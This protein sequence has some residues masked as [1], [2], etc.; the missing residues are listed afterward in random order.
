MDNNP[1]PTEKIIQYLDGDLTGEELEQFE[2]SLSND[3]QV[4]EELEN[5]TLAKKA[6]QSY[7]LKNQ[8][9]SVHRDM[10]NELNKGGERTL[11]SR[12][13]P[14]VRASLKIAA[15]LLIIS[16]SIGLYQYVTITPSKL[17]QDNYSP[18][19]VSVSRGEVAV[20]NLEKAYLNKD[21]NQAISIFE[22][23]AQPGAK[24]Y[25]LSSQAYMATHQPG[26]AIA[27]FNKLLIINSPENNLH[28]DAEYYLA[29]S[30]L[31]NN[32]PKKA[33]PILEK[34]YGDKDHLYHDRVSY[35]ELIKLRLLVFKAAGK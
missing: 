1:Q 24:D 17:Y 13:Y 25:F 14:F 19:Q 31:E 7:G 26:K 30:Y 21:F 12:I 16:V 29:S 32:E 10:M 23:M 5:L 11:E 28:D 34:I 35:W 3:P 15:S 6:V 27:G 8:V 18:Y 2:A 22:K 33:E 9:A 4:R 20:S